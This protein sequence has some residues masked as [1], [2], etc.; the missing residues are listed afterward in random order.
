MNICFLLGMPCCRIAELCSTS[1][2]ALQKLEIALHI[3][4]ETIRL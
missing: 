3:W 1:G 2:K 4:M